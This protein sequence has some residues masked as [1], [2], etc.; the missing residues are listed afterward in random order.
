MIHQACQL[1]GRA[2]SSNKLSILIYHQVL[3]KL[4]PMRP[5]EP[6]RERFRWQMKLLREHYNPLSLT[7]AL[8]LLKEERLPANSI[9]VTFD[10][11]YLNN[12]QVAQPILEEFNIPATVYIAT[13]FSTGINMWN[14]RLIDLIGNTQLSQLDLSALERDTVDLGDWAERRELVKRLI[15]LIKHRDYLDR[16]SVVDKLYQDNHQQELTTK[17]MTPEQVKEL[18]SLGIEIG[19]HT[20]DHPILKSQSLSEQ[21][22]QLSESKY[23]LENW[24]DKPVIGFAYP[25]GQPEYDYT[26][27]TVELV[28]QQG[29]EYAVSTSWG[30]STPSSDQWQ[31]NRFT[32]WDKSP[33]RFHLRLMKN[34]LSRG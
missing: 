16:Q 23:T 28:K 22:R 6:D 8:Q 18:A 26:P 13:A 20:I 19:A 30:I 31:L 15:P 12:L 24:L 17:M 4:D 32:P 33:Q 25:N 27:E 1:L 2:T 3:E 10:D 29:F 5:N 7:Q 34:V 9:C 11:G 14:D 21:Q